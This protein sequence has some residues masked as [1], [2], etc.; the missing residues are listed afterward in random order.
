MNL[1]QQIQTNKRNSVL[2][3]FVVLAAVIGAVAA[4]SYSVRGDFVL[5]IIAA[6]IAVPSSLIGYYQGDKIALLTNGAREVT[7]EAEPD[8]HNVVENLAITAGVPKPRVYMIDSPAMNAFATGRDPQHASVAVTSGLLAVLNRTELEGVLAHELA[9]VK[10]YDIRFG[11]LVAIFVGFV[12]VLSDLFTRSMWFGGG[13][14][15]GGNDNEGG[16]LQALLFIVGLVFLILSPIFAKLVQLAISRQREYLADSAGALLTR[17]PEGLASALEKISGSVPLK[18][19][20]QS[21]APLYIANPFNAKGVANL[22]S[23]HPPIADRI[24]RLRESA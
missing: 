10:N 11:T 4:Y 7:K 22:F 1:Y 17:Y 15:R 24:K 13:R 12:V 21:T 23:T 18:T 20:S 2:L 16:Q 5:P 9:H 14:R 8:L 19:A 6:I 3:I